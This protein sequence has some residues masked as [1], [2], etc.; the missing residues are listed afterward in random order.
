MST[1]Q[2]LS[3][4][5][6]GGLASGASDIWVTLEQK[7]TPISQNNA[8]LTDMVRMVAQAASGG[9]ARDYQLE[10][11]AA[12]TIGTDGSL[13]VTLTVYVWPNPPALPYSMSSSAGTVSVGT[14]IEMVREID[15]A[16]AGSDTAILPWN[17]IAG[18][19]E[20]QLPPVDAFSAPLST[21][22]DITVTGSKITLSGEGYGV[23]RVL[24]AAQGFSHKV[25]L[26]FNK[27]LPPAPVQPI[28]VP[29]AV[30]NPTTTTMIDVGHSL[31]SAKATVTASYIGDDGEPHAE[32]MTLVIPPCVLD[33]LE[34]CPDGALLVDN[35]DFASDMA[36][37]GVPT[38]YYDTCTGEVLDLRYESTSGGGEI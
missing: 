18:T 12:A 8:N 15:V 1:T 25:I 38:V 3:V 10:K 36:D 20:W 33:L 19:A 17:V 32:I 35:V 34:Y 37:G 24:G 26:R 7:T 31:V 2:Q 14:A 28:T 23:L 4:N 13:I 16:V 9:S 29:P 30:I 5:F 27:G 6:E 11:C 22:P 21:A